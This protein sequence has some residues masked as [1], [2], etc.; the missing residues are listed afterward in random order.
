MSGSD[1]LEIERKWLLAT[2]PSR[3]WL[4]A[5]GA[6]P[7]RIEQVYLRDAEGEAGGRRVRRIETEAGTTHVETRKRSLGGFTREE[8]ERPIGADAYERAL[9]DAEPTRRPVR[10]TRWVFEY[11]GHDLELDVFETPP[12][13]VLLEIEL[14]SED[15]AVSLPPDLAIVREVT[16]DRAYLN[17]N[18][19]RRP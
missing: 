9:A 7:K 16:D 17:W 1:D 3:E 14:Q 8:I 19:A 12:D 18:L 4:A 11:E 13:V 10:K 15:E 6:V 5:H 2:A